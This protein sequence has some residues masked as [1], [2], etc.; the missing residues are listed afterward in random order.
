RPA[1]FV[2]VKIAANIKP[3]N[4]VAV[5]NM[6][7]ASFRLNGRLRWP[8]PENNEIPFRN[9]PGQTRS[10]ATKQE[11]PTKITTIRKP[12]DGSDKP[13]PNRGIAKTIGSSAVSEYT[14]P[15]SQSTP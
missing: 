11:P 7:I 4:A 3:N 8:L 10:A 14:R 5:R 1:N 15:T 13:F 9:V 6:G 2:D 12:M